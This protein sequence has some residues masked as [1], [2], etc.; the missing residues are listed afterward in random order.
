[1]TRNPIE[2]EDRIVTGPRGPRSAENRGKVQLKQV[3]L[4]PS[5][6]M[7]N[8]LEPVISP[9]PVRTLNTCTL[10]TRVLK[11]YRAPATATQ[12]NLRW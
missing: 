7:L 10:R 11:G 6:S 5:R 3:N 12:Y 2:L 4:Q 9:I 8:R 1:M